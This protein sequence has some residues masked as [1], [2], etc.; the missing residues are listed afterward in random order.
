MFFKIFNYFVL[1]TSI[2]TTL[3]YAS[4]DEWN[5]HDFGSYIVT[6]VPGEISHGD[7]MRFILEKK[8]ATKLE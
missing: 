8:T 2:L 6:S 1:I 4:E 7:K 3:T 5:V